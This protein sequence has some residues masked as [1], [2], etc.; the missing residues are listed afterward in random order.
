MATDLKRRADAAVVPGHHASAQPTRKPNKRKPLAE[1]EAL[2]T[3][4]SAT[5]VK[6][7]GLMYKIMGAAVTN[8]LIAASPCIDQHLPKIER[9]EMRFL[10]PSEITALADSIDPRFRA[11]VILGAYGG[12]RIGEMLGLRAKCVDILHASVDVVENLVEVSGHLHYGPPK[13][14]AG[15]RS[16]PLPKVALVALEEHMRRER[17]GPNDLVFTAPEGGPVRLATWRRR[18]WAPAIAKAGLTPLR[19][20]DLRP[21]AVALWIEAGASHKEIAARGGHASVVTI[22]DRYGTG[23]LAPRSASTTHWTPWPTAPNR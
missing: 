8:G 10:S 11:L 23:S 15:R 1:G 9:A 3:L 16:V 21:T 5:V 22:L 19:T 12:L 2:K 7:S 4:A 17:L 20:H 14:K 13:T 6:A 18:V